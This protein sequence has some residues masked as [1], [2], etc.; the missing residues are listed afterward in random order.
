[1]PPALLTRTSIRSHR[2]RRSSAHCRT[3]A[4]SAKSRSETWTSSEPVVARTSAAATSA[5]FG[6]RQA[7]TM[8]APMPARATAVSL[9][10]PEF[11]PVMTTTLPCMSIFFRW[12][13]AGTR[14]DRAGRDPYRPYLGH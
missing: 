10:M 8:V 5:I 14:W 13:V 2:L 6:L 12:S 7:S 3:E 4:R 1:M 9:P 11:A